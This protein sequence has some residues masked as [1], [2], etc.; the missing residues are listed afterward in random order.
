MK[1]QILTILAAAAIVSAAH[2]DYK[3]VVNETTGNR[4]EF[5]FKNKPV[6]TFTADD[7]VISVADGSKVEYPYAN[8]VN[9][10]LEE[11]NSIDG[12]EAAGNA[13]FSIDNDTFSAFN[14]PARAEIRIFSINGE[15]MAAGNADSEGHYSTGISGLAKG[16]YIVKAGD[17]SFKFIR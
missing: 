1:R 9:L 16:V 4:I 15:T 12:I 8:V 3:L 5:L 7:L 2:A 17:K 6:A 10:T 13:A 11:F 14:L